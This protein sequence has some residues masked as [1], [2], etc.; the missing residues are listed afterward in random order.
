VVAE[1]HLT[2]DEARMLAVIGQRLDR[3]PKGKVT[4]ERVLEMIRYLGCVQLDTISVVARSHETVL[5]S[6]LGAFDPQDV[7]RLYG[8]G[9]LTEYWAHAAAI[10]PIEMIPYFR[11]AMERRASPDHDYGRWLIEHQGVVDEVLGTITAQGAVTSRAFARPDGPRPEA[12]AWYGG[13]PEKEALSHLWTVGRLTVV[14][15]NGFERLFDL[16]ERVVP[17][18]LLAER[19]SPAEEMAFFIRRALSAMGIAKQR[20]IRDYFR[21]GGASHLPL[22][23]TAEE[24]ER[25]TGTGE[26]IP[27][28][29][30]GWD[31]PAWLHRALLPRLDELR[32]GRGRPTLTTVLSPFDNLVWHRERALTLFDFDYR[33]ECY[34][35]EQ[36]RIYGYYTLPLLHRG[37]LIGRLDLHYARKARLMTVKAAHLEP[38]ERPTEAIAKAI[39]TAV[40]DYLRFLGGG[41]VVIGSSNPSALGPLL[42][43]AFHETADETGPDGDPYQPVRRGP[44]G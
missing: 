34:T 32:A 24:L 38:R 30:T 36:K 21:T 17:A 1:L 8:E 27:V 14:Q 35:P 23:E 31:E 19:P 25:M 42:S 40:R 10:I 9:C 5:Y 28:A 41:R 37:R 3:R 44:S 6:R 15:R 16:T 18:A 43:A 33:L 11:R 7:W 2:R 39:V 4:L 29:V 26:A 20:W 12:W 22:R 13:K